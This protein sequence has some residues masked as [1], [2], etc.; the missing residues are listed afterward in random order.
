MISTIASIV[1]AFILGVC[2]VIVAFLFLLTCALMPLGVIIFLL[3]LIVWRLYSYGSI[4][5]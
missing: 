1:K 4:R 3:I 5:S 2:F